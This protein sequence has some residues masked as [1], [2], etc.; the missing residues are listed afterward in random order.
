MSVDENKMVV[1]RFVE[2]VQGQHKLDLAEE[3]MSS[4]MVDHYFETQGIPHTENAV[5]EF[6]K[7]YSNLL[8]AFPDIT[9]VIHHQVA[10]GDLVATYKTLYG[11]HKGEF[12]GIQ[13]TGKKIALDLMD[14]FR[15]TDGKIV[16]HWAVIDFMN[17]MRQLG[18]V[19]PVK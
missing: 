7:F 2:E 13:P 12:R 19:S 10:E 5:K 16:E 17:L 8:A 4:K 14:F 6:N 11:T 3:L 9:A 18:A 15:L 1:R